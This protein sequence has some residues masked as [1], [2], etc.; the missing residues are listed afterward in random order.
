MPTNASA[1]IVRRPDL[2]VVDVSTATT[3]TQPAGSFSAHVVTRNV[4]TKRAGASATTFALSFDQI[5]GASD[6]AMAGQ[7]NV[8]AL[9]KKTSFPDDDVPL[10]VPAVI[11]DGRYFLIACADGSQVVRERSERNNCLATASTIDVGGPAVT[12]TSPTDGATT[13]PTGT[14]VYT[15]GD[16]TSVA[17][18][19]DASPVACDLSGS[20]PFNG[21][22][23]GQHTIAVTGTD[24]DGLKGTDSVTWSV[25]GSAP[26]VTS[27]SV[28]PNGA[29]AV[30]ASFALSDMSNI[31]A[32][33]C[34]LDGSDAACGS[35]SSQAYSSLS[36]GSH[37]LEV[38]GVDEWGNSGS[39]ATPASVPAV[40]AHIDFSVVDPPAVLRLNEVNANQ[41]SG[42]DL[43]ELR[44]VAGGTMSGATVRMGVTTPTTLATLP[45]VVV[46]TNDLIVVHLTP[47]V[48]VTTDT[49][50]KTDCT[51]IACY[52]GA[53]DV[54]GGATGITFSNQVLTVNDSGG[55]IGDGVAFVNGTSSSLSTYPGELQALQGGGHWQPADCGGSPCTY[56]TTPDAYAVSADWAGM[57]STTTGNSVRR[58]SATDS[59]AAADWAVGAQSF[60]S[61]NP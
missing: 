2:K 3:T 14:I 30:I 59:D 33:H 39:G 34:E 27:L 47:A 7:S 37:A 21:L 49:T 52:A 11:P 50:S 18:V 51:D 43:V 19:L 58:I 45:D 4:G 29:Y 32:V 6:L 9:A 40:R 55:A 42:T 54:R 5:H 46:A 12:V 28:S 20:L 56:V 24:A 26:V 17:C 36:A 8:P 41:A 38:Y 22:T 61:P 31:S 35:S 1:R 13:P 53:W 48:G 10:T 44:V 25:D 23:D 57:G 60:G 15:T 16:A